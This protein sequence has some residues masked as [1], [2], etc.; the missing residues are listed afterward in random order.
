M[1]S[2]KLTTLFLITLTL[3][4]GCNQN[5]SK[6]AERNF[7]PITNEK[8][9]NDSPN[10]NL[11][12]PKSLKIIKSAETRYK[13]KNVKFTTQKIKEFVKKYGGYVSGLRFR[14]NVYQLENT[15]T[16][17][18]PQEEFDTL[19]DSINNSAEFVDYENITTKDITE[20]YVDLESRL[21]TKQEVKKR[22]ES[23]LRKQAKT[24]EEILE[25]EE[26]LG[27][28]Q[29]EIEAVQG[30]LKYYSNR[31]SYSTIK[32]NLYEI[33]EHKETPV[34]YHKSFGVKIKEGFSNGWSMVSMIFLGI[35]N[36]WPLIIIGFVSL[37]VIK[38]RK[39]K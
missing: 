17:R 22:L 21:Q 29:E 33:V 12:F 1:N 14:N 10:K 16:I 27:E 19:L 36:V 24:V 6:H 30:K 25:T 7:E 26:K 4:Q 3:L 32:I 39:I 28:I 37:F 5:N 8:I 2:I 13:V 35:I 31:V 9:R 20:E 38:K 23:I 34:S 15:F 18:V 11:E